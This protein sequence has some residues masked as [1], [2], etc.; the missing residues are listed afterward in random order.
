LT[1]QPLDKTIRAVRVLSFRFR[2]NSFIES[3]FLFLVQVLID[4]TL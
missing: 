2:F 1:R 3:P 4:P